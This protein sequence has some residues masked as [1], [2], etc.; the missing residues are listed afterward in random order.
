MNPAAPSPDAA[1]GD[2]IAIIGVGC[3]FPGADGPV[4]FWRLLEGGVNAVIEAP[5]SRPGFAE[6]FDADPKKPGRAYTR[7]GG[8]L[9]RVDLFDAQF[10]GISPR[11]AA[12]IDPQH[13]LL[14]ELVWE[15]CEDAG[16]P[17]SAL[18]GTRTGVFIGI[19]THDYGDLQMYP[20]RR[21]DIDMHTNS[22]TATSIAAN[23]ISY[24]YDL[25][26]PSVAVDTACSSSLTAVHLSCQSLRAGECDVALAGGVQILL[27]P[28]L[29]IGF[30]KASML[31]PD[32]ECRAFDIDANGYVRGEG[33]GVV[34]LKPLAAAL[35]DGDPIYAVIRATAIN[36]DGRTTGMTVPSPRAQ[37]AMIEEALRKAGLQ[38]RDVQ[39]VEAHGPGTRVGDPI[40]A[41]AISAA[42][43]PG[44][45]AGETCAIG[46]VK[47][48][49]GHL[50]AASGMPGLIKVALSLQHRQIPPSLHFHQAND[51]IDLPALSLRVVTELEPWPQPERP[52]F[53]GVNSFGFGGANAHV[54]LQ[55]PPRRPPLLD[56]SE[57][58]AA[59]LLV[60]SARS[61]EALTAL[62]TEYAQHLTGQRQ[63]RMQDVCFTSAERRS[64]HDFRLS[65]VASH[66]DEFA[67]LLTDFT[68][69][70][71]GPSLAAGRAAPAGPPRVAFVFSGMGPQWWGMGRQLRQTEAV[72]RQMLERCDAALRPYAGWSLLDELAA[73]ESVSR[74]A[75]PELAQV[76]NFAIQ[77][78]LADVWMS[79]GITP[80]AVIGHSGGA[81]AAAY[82]AGVYD[83][84][85]ALRLSFHRSR[86]QGRPTNA[87]RMLAV[88]A[89]FAEVASLL[90]GAEARISLAAVNG[91]AAITL[92]GDGDTLEIVAAALLER[93]TFARFLPVTIAY[94]S[95]AMDPIREEFLSAV[96]GLQGKAARIPWLSDTTG[97]WVDGPECDVEFWW[98]AIRQPVLFRD[99]IRTMLDE[100]LCHFVEVSPH[101]VLTT[102]IVDCLKEH[103]TRG[104][105]VPSLR[106]KEDE[107][108]VMLRS[109]GALYAAGC[110]PAWQALRQEDARLEPLPHYPWQRERH[111]FEPTTK[112]D[113]VTSPV[114]T[115]GD[116][117]LL[118]ARLRSA[119]P[120]WE[121]AAGTDDTEYLRQHIVQGAVVC[122][123]AAYVEMALAARTAI[124]GPTSMVVRDVEFLKA[125][126]LSVEAATPMQFVLDADGHFEIFASGPGEGTSWAC[127]ARGVVAATRRAEDQHVDLDHLRAQ[128]PDETATDTFYDRMSGR[129]LAYGP[130]FRGIHRLWAANRQALASISTPEVGDVAPYCVHPALLDAAFQVLVGAADSDAA[131]AAGGHLFLPTG[132]REVRFHARPGGA[133]W[134]TAVV[135]EVTASTVLGDL[136]IVGADGQVCV[137]FV[138]FTARLVAVADHRGEESVDQWLYDYRWEPQSLEGR[139]ADRE[140]GSSIATSVLGPPSS[141][142]ALDQLRRGA[143]AASVTAGWPAYYDHVEW[144][145]NELA[146]AYAVRAFA[147][148]GH[149]LRSDA[150]VSPEVLAVRS[151]GEWRRAL[152]RQLL[153]NVASAG[154][155][156]Q[157]GEAWE[158][159]GQSPRAD[160]AVLAA[161]LLK[162]FPGHRLDVELL[163]RAGP[164]LADV[165]SG[166]ADGRDVL[167][168]DEG[169][170][171]L[172]QFYRESPASA[173]YNAQV[174]SLVR[175]L[176]TGASTDRPLRVLEVGAGTGGTTSLVV[177]QLDGRRATYVFSDVSPLF[178]ERAR[179]KFE[180][181]PF[182]STCLF[183]VTRP[184]AAQ[185][186]EPRSFD[187][188]IGANVLHATPDVEAA[189]QRLR[190]LVAPGG[191]M[192]LLEIT[193]HPHW[194]DTVFGLMDGWWALTD[195]QRR[196]A[197]PLMPGR[198][199]QRLL[200]ECGL[201]S[202]AVV[203]DEAVGEPAQSIII[204][205]QPSAAAV[206]ATAPAAPA[207]SLAQRWVI[208]ADRQRNV[209]RRLADILE[210]RGFNTSV[211]FADT[212]VTG[213]ADDIPPQIESVAGIIHVSSLDAPT[214]DA[215]AGFELADRVGC[216]SLLS[217]LQRIVHGSPLAERRLVVVTAGAETTGVTSG[218]PALLQAPVWGFVRTLRK[219]WP[220]LQCSLV[221][222]SADCL[223]AEILALADEITADRQSAAEEE[224]A[225]RAD[226]RFVHRLRPTSRMKMA[227]AAPPVPVAGNGAWRA[228]IPTVGSLDSLVF[229][230]VERTAPGP[231]EVEVA[232]EAASLNFRDVVVATGVVQGLE[233]DTSFGSRRLGID[234]AGTVTRCGEGVEHLKIGDAVLG[235]AQG[236]FASHAVTNASLVVRR[237]S[238]LSAEEASTVPVAFVTVWYALDR[239]ARLAKGESVLIHAAS[240]GVGLAAIQI[241][242][243]VGAR[244]FATAGSPVKRAFVEALGVEAVMDSRTLD[245][246]EE[247]RERTG[248]RGVDVVLNSLP[249]EA[250]ARGFAALAPYGRFVELGKADIYQNHRLDLG[251]FRKNLS[252]FAVDLDRMCLERAELVGQMLREVSDLFAAGELQAPVR[253][254]FDMTQLAE[255]MRFMGQAKHI[256]KVVVS[257][258]RDV[259]VRAPLPA[260]PPIR[261]DATYLITGGRGGVGL[262][263]ARW[264]V[265]L[266]ARTLVLMGRSVPSMEAEITMEELRALGARVEVATADVSK[267]EDVRQVVAMIR[268]S[269]PRLGGVFHAAMVLD[270]RPLD[271][272][273][274]ASLD[275]VMAPKARGA[276]HLH[277]ETLAEPLDFFVSFSSIT[278]LLGNPFQANYA[279]ANAYLDTFATYRRRLGFAATTINW[280]VI[281]GEGYVARHQEIEG[282]LN[283]QGYLS[284]TPEQTLEVL[285]EMLRHDATKVMAARIDWVRFGEVAA[286]AAA[287]PQ[288]RHLVPVA[289]HAAGPATSGSLRAE[290]AA[291][292]PAARVVRVED[293]LRVQTARLIGAAPA[294]IDLERP[295]TDLGLDSLIAVELAL[296]L[297]RDC[298]VE[299]AGSKLLG[300]MSLRRLAAD[301]LSLMH[302]E[303]APAVAVSHTP[304]PKE[305]VAAPRRAIA[306]ALPEPPV[307][308]VP[309]PLPV[310]EV[311]PPAPVDYGALD[312]SRWSP[313][314]RL[315]KAATTA[316]FA[317]LARIDVQGAEHIPAQGPCV[318]AVNHLSM[319]DVPLVL[320]L[321]PRR[322][323]ILAVDRLKQFRILDWFVSDMGQAI[324]VTRDQPEQESLRQA[325]AVLRAGGLLALAPEGTRSRTGGLLRGRTGVAYLATHA[326]APVVPLVAW[327]QERWRARLTQ[328]QRIPIHVRVGAPMQFP[329]GAASPAD[330]RRYTDDIMVALAGLL[331]SQY[332]GVYQAAVDDATERG[333]GQ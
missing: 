60:L 161:E 68:V 230:S 294:A 15:A 272:M 49:L 182:V 114:R 309:A 213:I 235:I 292:S 42:L 250:I 123:G 296:V 221:D 191:A 100:G 94:H 43:S 124:D 34:L 192:L 132:I 177:P 289:A 17:P 215:G 73:D 209:G 31:S 290:L 40:E 159:T 200:E 11:E 316:G 54:V 214:P 50:E 69:G 171:F 196:P 12:H 253:T 327:G 119:R 146:A 237:P 33:A 154:C 125:L 109:L 281:A 81:M 279:A 195:R 106:R 138:G 89:P 7:W 104:V 174:A 274:G 199:W 311:L 165:L 207:A 322:A 153:Q 26:G 4:A 287:S 252:L 21:G 222:L 268:S 319:A 283:N 155:A 286:R 264:L 36:Q 90:A 30:C 117:P 103:G 134:V 112:D 63:P 263:V 67:R 266:G 162:N 113:R 41:T 245:F 243:R 317:G 97:T 330:L 129:G 79:R 164:R 140:P 147:E 310:A 323:V 223:D 202:V 267:A 116:H 170:R 244:I 228:E 122:P 149:P 277:T 324:Y 193:R 299:I 57:G 178:L 98:R 201:E 232:I 24:L 216:A 166:R 275:R 25:R 211:Y 205:R 248:G 225:L 74:V 197:H 51:A 293:Y 72:F 105:A 77:V 168:T 110:M 108:A 227:E 261:P 231:G 186:L 241:A 210:R 249:G 118:G 206:A 150:H 142:P 257:T 173:F 107:R 246:A 258:H 320:T 321:L 93:Q 156:R 9:D 226:L 315:I 137:E 92:A 270:D 239:L 91:P 271:T 148:L 255:A 185:G 80:A 14:L 28:E 297:E 58:D 169:F 179:V 71:G 325:V 52:A 180:A 262:L 61:P 38:P 306:E 13:R 218:V 301:I 133:F 102:A 45:A 219:E 187:L 175:E 111:W 145:L 256:G 188:V 163:E 16:V 236:T 300:G 333:A 198:A 220:S 39:Y 295:I 101:P 208:V 204:G 46:S 329:G 247:I 184:T 47:T 280:G 86:L 130:A 127:H 135:R 234:L 157:V 276:W 288:L 115:A 1:P 278:S 88:G 302:L 307:D 83:L 55:E 273:D 19:S 312:Y 27:T 120:T 259:L 332:R 56:I 160:V 233:S 8:F 139:E 128:C 5:A 328:V 10:F 2:G 284:F 158:A 308:L 326:N 3:R 59:R 62:A 217:V 265:G 238:H 78:A 282:Y 84:E 70:A 35:A 224:I 29:T 32:G 143:T 37:Q 254:H 152:A 96:A 189:V 313:T 141:G 18:A 181:Y 53:A 190:E 48:N 23:R 242:R 203:A 82:V 144:R 151:P 95:P 126:R 240:G 136:R 131:L 304:P 260:H 318:L 76:T 183:D 176:A 303:A 121:N 87:G 65:V 22:G 194:L 99:G 66:R 20:S 305:V 285:S 64:H 251:P 298:G 85:D 6:C 172:E 331:P 269:L 229:R 291:D 314:Q 75:Q 212:D 167:F 44:R